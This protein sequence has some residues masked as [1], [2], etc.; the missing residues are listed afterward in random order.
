MPRRCPHLL[1]TLALATPIA[2][3]SVAFAQDHAAPAASAPAAPTASP[4]NGATTAPAPPASP[5][6]DARPP[7]IAPTPATPVAPAPAMVS[8]SAAPPAREPQD[9]AKP[10]TPPD[11]GEIAAPGNEVF[12]EDWW[13]RARPVVELHGY[14]RTRAELFQNFSLGRHSSVFQGTDPQY[15]CAHP[16]RSELPAGAGVQ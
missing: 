13:G 10:T 3:P 14:F 15:L 5:A 7:L 16:A 1:V 4:P 11:T 6:L 2:M 12:S 8:P 9:A